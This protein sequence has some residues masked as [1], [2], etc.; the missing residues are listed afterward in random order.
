M[1]VDALQ[2]GYFDFDHPVATD[3]RV[4]EERCILCGACATNC[5]TGAMKMNDIGD[6]RVL[7]LCGTILNRKELLHC[8]TCGTVLGPTRYLDFVKSRTQAVARVTDDRNLCDL[9]AR[10]STAK[11]SADDAPV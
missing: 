9:C 6:E 8:E 7:S 2:M 11:S 4:T 3:Y 10:K 1:S 5:P